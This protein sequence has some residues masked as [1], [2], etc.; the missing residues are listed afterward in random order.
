MNA[1]WMA[2]WQRLQSSPAQ[3]SEYIILELPRARALTKMVRDEAPPL[4]FLVETKADISFMKIV[5]I[6][7]E[8]MQGIT[9]P[10]NGRGGG[11]AL[12]WKEASHVEVHNYSHSH[13][14]VIISDHE[15]NLGW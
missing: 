9:V 10:S 2:V 5:Q 11:L 15:T 13:I 8:Y 14:D 4:V 7:L 6:K 3:L 12:L 1:T